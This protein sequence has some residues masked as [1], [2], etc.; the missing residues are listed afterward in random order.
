MTWFCFLPNLL[1]KIMPKKRAMSRIS[2]NCALS[3][4]LFLGWWQ[5]PSSASQLAW[6]SKLEPHFDSAAS[7]FCRFQ[8]VYKVANSLVRPN[9]GLWSDLCVRRKRGRKTLPL[10]GSSSNCSLAKVASPSMPLRRSV[11]PQTI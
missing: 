3:C 11:L 9:K 2:R 8:N 10:K 1:V 6:K 5:S 7:L 4:S